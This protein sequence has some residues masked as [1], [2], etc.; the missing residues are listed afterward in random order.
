MTFH[1]RTSPGPL[2]GR[3]SGKL[4]LTA[5]WACLGLGLV[6]SLLVAVAAAWYYP[7][8]PDLDKVTR[9]QPQ[10]ALQVFTS[11]G[12]EIAQ[13]GSERREFLPIAQI[14]QQMQDA[15]R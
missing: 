9:Y 15:V 2:A 3:Q 6:G 4:W 11:D 14:P 8:L 10:Q 7:N 5:L 1:T 13:F 12:V